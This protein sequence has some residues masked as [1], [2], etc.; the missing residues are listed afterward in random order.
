MTDRRPTKAYGL[1]RDKDGRPKFD[2][3]T[4]IPRPLWNLLTHTEQEEV[5]F[6]GGNPEGESK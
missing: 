1:V 5:R 3:I 2:N 6:R 4:N